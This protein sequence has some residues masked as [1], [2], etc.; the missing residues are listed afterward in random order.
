MRLSSKQS[1]LSP[2]TSA[3]YLPDS[4]LLGCFAS[5]V[6]RSP[7]RARIAVSPLLALDDKAVVASAALDITDPRA[8]LSG[9]ESPAGSISPYK[10]LPRIG[11]RKA[12]GRTWVRTRDL[13]RVKRAL[14]H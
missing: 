3:G 1:G 6:R 12:N 7:R 9:W 10:G 13:S 14:S 11:L 8:A 5:A 2:S 4:S